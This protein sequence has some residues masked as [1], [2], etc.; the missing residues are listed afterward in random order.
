MKTLIALVAVICVSEPLC[1][2]EP[3]AKPPAALAFKMKTLS[4]KEVDLSQFEKDWFAVF[5][6]IL[7]RCNRV[8]LKLKGL[9]LDFNS[10]HIAIDFGNLLSFTFAINPFL[11][12]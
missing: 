10:I 4:G 12:N 7:R 5:C 6:Q 2:D 9:Y 11:N 8:R 1:A 3:D